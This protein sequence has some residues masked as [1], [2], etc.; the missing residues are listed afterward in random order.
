[1]P[2]TPLVS[3]FPYQ[4]QRR[5]NFYFRDHPEQ[6]HPRSPLYDKY[7]GEFEQKVIEGVWI[8]DEG[9]WVYM[10][11]KLFFYVN[12]C[13]IPDKDRNVILPDLRD[14]EWII[15]TYLLCCEGFSGFEGDEEY[16][17]H[18]HIRRHESTK[19]RDKLD[20]IEF[21][22]IPESCKTRS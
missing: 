8:D 19:E 4:I 1:M 14:N 3:L 15:F 18:D 22:E 10:M 17:S 6:V 21:A 20:A 2:D 9:T 11:P 5:E 16:T 7:W 13:R 12:Y